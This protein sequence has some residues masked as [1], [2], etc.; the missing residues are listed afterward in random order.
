M[1][2]WIVNLLRGI[3]DI[4]YHIGV[5]FRSVGFLCDFTLISFFL[6]FLPLLLLFSHSFILPL[7]LSLKLLILQIYLLRQ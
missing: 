2:I 7:Q 1:K 4:E 5:T 3:S 6:L